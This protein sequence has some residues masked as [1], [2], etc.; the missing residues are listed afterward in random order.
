[1]DHKKG[2]IFKIK[3]TAGRVQGNVKYTSFSEMKE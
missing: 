3:Q 1:M 2:N